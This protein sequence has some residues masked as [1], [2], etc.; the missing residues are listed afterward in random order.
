[1]YDEGVRR[2]W[3]L[4]CHVTAGIELATVF[5]PDHGQRTCLADRTRRGAF[6]V[7]V[8]LTLI[9]ASGCSAADARGPGTVHPTAENLAPLAPAIRAGVVEATSDASALRDLALR[10]RSMRRDSYIG[11]AN[12]STTSFGQLAGAAAER[13]G[14][15]LIL[16]RAMGRISIF[17][18]GS[19]AGVVAET[20]G[21]PAN[22]DSPKEMLLEDDRVLLIVEMGR[23]VKSF[24]KNGQTYVYDRTRYSGPRVE[25]ACS[26]GRTLYVMGRDSLNRLVHAVD[27]SARVL[28]SFAS[29]YRDSSGLVRDQLSRGRIACDAH[30]KS[31]VV[32]LNTLPYLTAYDTSGQVKWRLE[33]KPFQPMRSTSWRPP[34]E[35]VSRGGAAPHDLIVSVLS[36]EPGVLLVQV[37][38]VK[39]RVREVGPPTLSSY[40][41][42]V[43]QGDASF[44]SQEFP[45]VGA[46]SRARAVSFELTPVPRIALYTASAP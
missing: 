36:V 9:G 21:V 28:R 14:R 18:R 40:L 26:I 23:R 44:V 25:G 4:P 17:E 27:D 31:V 16:D 46:L 30:S 13:S 7:L 8:V 33:I 43:E 45:L 10:L 19:L 12:D 38:H 3:R 34:H 37:A 42:S 29:G 39:G 22:L 15:V 24:V 32:S 2:E 41:V 11:S 1:M 35:A 20:P 5:Q 6:A